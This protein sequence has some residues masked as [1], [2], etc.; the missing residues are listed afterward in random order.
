M[1]GEVST[2]SQSLLQPTARTVRAETV[3]K[4]D[5][6]K[7]E[8]DSKK[9]EEPQEAAH[10]EE[11]IDD[12]VVEMNK[13]AQQLH[14]E[15]QFSTSE[16]SGMIVIKVVDKETDEVIREIPSEEVQEMR[17]RLSEAAGMIFRDSA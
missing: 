17:K 2:V 16:E 3:A 5:E 10:Q 14:R 15:L 12:V 9:S 4:A 6:E 1:T 7:K 13:M 11:S 8:V